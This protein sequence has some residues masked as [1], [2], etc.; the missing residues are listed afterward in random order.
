MNK[1]FRAIFD[2]LK[3]SKQETLYTNDRVLL[4]D[5]LNTFLRSFVM[6]NHTNPQGNHIGGLTGYLKSIGFAIKLIKPTRVILVFDGLGGSTNKQY[7]YPEYKANRKINKITNWEGFETREDEAESITNQIIRLIDYLKCLPV[8][9]LCIDKI[10][11][12]DVIAYLSNNMDGEIHIM[13]SDKDYIQ[14]VSD[15]VTVYSPVKKKFYRPKEVKEELKVPAINYLNY[16]VLLGDPSDNVPGVRGL[17]PKGA[18]KLFP[19]LQEERKVTLQEIIDMSYEKASEKKAY[20]SVYNYRNQ[21]V[22]NEK[23]MD[24]HNPNVPEEDITVIEKVMANP[25]K[26]LDKHTF[27]EMYNEDNLGNSIPN[28]SMWLFDVFDYLK[29]IKNK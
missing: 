4:V 17:G 29:N 16:K 25:S 6:I 5:S 2:S 24:L 3:E 27:L 1:D 10:E 18:V 11:A 21:L 19:Q 14:L 13:S 7:L 23:L 28:T 8:D 22:I 12:D 15:R 20:Q 9:L 26:T